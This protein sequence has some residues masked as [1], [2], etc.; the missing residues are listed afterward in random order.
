M[1]KTPITQEFEIDANLTQERPIQ[2]WKSRPL[3]FRLRQRWNVLAMLVTRRIS[4]RSAWLGLR[5]PNEVKWLLAR[6]SG[7][8]FLPVCPEVIEEIGHIDRQLSSTN[9]CTEQSRF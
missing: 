1:S 3:G 7:T 9:Q 2:P 4:W 5:Y 6:P 8:G